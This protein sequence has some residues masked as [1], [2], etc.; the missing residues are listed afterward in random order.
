MPYSVLIVLFPL[1]GALVNGVFGKRF[2][3]YLIAGIGCLTVGL[4]FAVA[5][6]A[7]S[8]LLSLAP[9]ERAISEK[10]FTWIESGNVSV[11]AAFLLDPLSVVMILVVTGVGFLIHIYSVAYMAEEP[12]YYRFFSYLNLFIFMMS[13]L[14]LADNYLLM[15]VGWEGVGLCSYLLIGFYFDRKSAGDAAK[16]AFIVNRIG[17]VGF[18]LGAFLI[19]RTFGT[20]NYLEVFQRVAD[21]FPSAEV[22]FGLLS[23][24]CLLLFVGAT[25]KSAQIPL[26]VW[27]PDA[28]EGPTPVSALI[29]AATMVTA[30][31]YMVARSAALFSRAPETLLIVA[32][33]GTATAILAACIA[34]VQTDIKRVLAYS[35]VS[36]LGYM[37][38]AAGVGAFGS[39]IFHV[40]THAFFKAL[41]FLGSGSVIL[42]LHHEQD[43]FRMGGLKKYLPITFWTMWVAT[44]AI[45]GVPP[46]AGFFSKDEIL[47][48]AFSLG[49]VVL[50][51][52]GVI[53]ASLTAFYMFRLMFLAFHGER[54]GTAEHHGE[55]HHAPKEPSLLVTGPL[56]ILA[57]FSAVAGFLGLPAYLGTNRLESFLEPSFEH[58]LL[59]H[60]AAEH[61]SNLEIA[62]TVVT[63]LA[64]LTGILIAYYAYIRDR[65]LPSRFANRFRG[66]YLAARQ[67]FYVDEVYDALVVTPI[68]RISE[69]VLWR[70]ID[71]HLIDGIVN[72]TGGLVQY[73][74]SG[75]RRI[76]SGYTRSYATWVLI[77][78]V[79]IFIYYYFATA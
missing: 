6:L 49:H 47:W 56:M 17:D 71:V 67:K 75:L 5:S 43:L 31:V 33:I 65:E 28:M 39:G 27:L 62:L 40:V 74:A 1:L 55:H 25:G 63:I 9:G 32:V 30:G 22:G 46:F 66:A 36:Q 53:V 48:N 78:A 8:Q 29:H 19:F 14:V 18:I 3:R 79:L 20:F 69:V 26:Y 60:H 42:A 45:S 10:I 23:A 15:F 13:I 58:R 37:F 70:A 61:S 24:I 50:W 35:T 38:L 72:G 76:Q 54:R 57:L 52:I 21:Q 68:R 2:P 51:V 34:L 12:G 41:L 59:E 73:W 16:K 44:L 7:L 64:G 4:S 77:G 11:D